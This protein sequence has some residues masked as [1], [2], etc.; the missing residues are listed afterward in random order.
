MTLVSICA[1]IRMTTSSVK[2]EPNNC[3]N[4][5]AETKR[6]WNHEGREGPQLATGAGDERGAIEKHTGRLKGFG[7]GNERSE[8]GITT[9]GLSSLRVIRHSTVK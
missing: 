7:F 8:R 9:R 2:A 4:H 3:G 6:G 5:E 1:T